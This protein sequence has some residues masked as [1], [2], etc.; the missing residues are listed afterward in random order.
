MTFGRTV[1]DYELCRWESV[2]RNTAEVIDLK[3]LI[4]KLNFE[5]KRPYSRLSPTNRLVFAP[6][7]NS[8]GLVELLAYFLAV[9]GQSG[10]QLSIFMRS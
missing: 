2:T 4:Q 3:L 10:A 8:G 7:A 9:S 1:H 5:A 6:G